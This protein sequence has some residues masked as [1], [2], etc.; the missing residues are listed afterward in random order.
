MTTKELYELEIG[1][2]CVINRGYS[3]GRECKVVLI[4]EGTI[5]VRSL[6]GKPFGK[7]NV[8]SRKLSLENWRNLDIVK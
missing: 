4:D 2:V 3:K 5:C 6:D 8:T 1:D 7:Y